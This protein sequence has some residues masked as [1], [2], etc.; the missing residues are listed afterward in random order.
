M[1]RF[2][3]TVFLAASLTAHARQPT[4][5]KAPRD[6]VALAVEDVMPTGDGHVVFLRDATGD[7]IVPINVGESE[8]ITIAFRLADRPHDRPFS[9]DLLEEAVRGLGGEIVQVHIHTLEE[10]VFHARVTIRTKKNQKLHLDSRASDA[11]A[12]AVGRG[13]P[14]YMAS[15]VY[16]DTA[17][18]MADLLQSLRELDGPVA[19]PMRR[20]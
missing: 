8:A 16:E 9:H 19:V 20:E 12:L 2:I 15:D 17:V 5:E 11:V 4:E 10:G 6:S 7:H 13:L 1:R 14:I 3:A 18:S